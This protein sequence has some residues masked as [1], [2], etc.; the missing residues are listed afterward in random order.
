[1]PEVVASY[2]E[3]RDWVALRKIYDTIIAG[4]MDDTE[5][6]AK[7]DTHLNVICHILIYGWRFAGQR[8]KFE[9]FSNSN[10]KSRKMGVLNTR[11]HSLPQ[12]PF[13]HNPTKIHTCKIYCSTTKRCKAVVIGM[14]DYGVCLQEIEPDLTQ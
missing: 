4:F 2:S 8:I 5:K 14:N 12:N 6:Y 13:V 7:N 10:Y 3:K 11:V 1:M 9:N